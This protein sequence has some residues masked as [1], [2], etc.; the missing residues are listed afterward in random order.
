MLAILQTL[1]KVYG[2]MPTRSPSKAVSDDK[3]MLSFF[4]MFSPLD[5]PVKQDKD[6]G[7]FVSL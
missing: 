3:I 1:A 4:M 2:A 7:G 6:K 5:C